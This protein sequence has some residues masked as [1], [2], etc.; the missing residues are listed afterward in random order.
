M[1]LV[2]VRHGESSWNAE[3]RFQG[4]GG[5]GLSE[6]GHAQAKAVAELLSREYP[7][8][9]LLV[10]SDSAR[11]A[12]TAAPI[13]AGL[14]IEVR[15]DERLREIDVG[16]WTG[17]TRE[18]IAAHDPSGYVAWA[19]GEPDSRRG[20]GET[21]AELRARVWQVLCEL[22]VPD[23]D[24][25]MLVVTH[26]GPIRVAVA[27]VLDLPPGAEQ[28]LA[29]VGNGALTVLEWRHGIPRLVAYNRPVPQVSP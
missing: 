21:Y 20:G 2:L 16:T 13:E 15:V 24:V 23:G 29:G 25:T 4:H 1:R 10:R 28:R 7:D 22:V 8:A 26:G 14:G 17:L 5:T 18:E 9:V 27:A 11:V 19:R 3:G 12:E 6:V